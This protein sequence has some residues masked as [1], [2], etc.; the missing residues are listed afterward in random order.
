[1]SGKRPPERPDSSRSSSSCDVRRHSETKAARM[2]S[3]RKDDVILSCDRTTMF[4]SHS[5]RGNRRKQTSLFPLD[6]AEMRKI[7][8]MPTLTNGTPQ[9]IR[10]FIKNIMTWFHSLDEVAAWKRPAVSWGERDQSIVQ[11]HGCV[12]FHKVE[13]MRQLTRGMC[14][15]SPWLSPQQLWQEM[16]QKPQQTHSPWLS[17]QQLWQ[18]TDHACAVAS[19]ED[20]LAPCADLPARAWS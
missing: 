8:S 18:A 14:G 7:P 19:S 13:E 10:V 9:V 15:L 3:K 6:A 20:V 11:R 17:P 4:W 5:P 1:M 2:H 16:G 12:W